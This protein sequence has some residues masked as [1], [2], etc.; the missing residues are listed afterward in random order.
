MLSTAIVIFRETLEIALMLGIVLT[1]TRGLPRRTPWIAGGFLAGAVGA[2][3]VASFAEAISAFAAGVGQEIF[4]ACILFIA[5]GF[6]GCTALW[7]HTHAREMS[8]RLKKIGQDVTD[9]ALPLSALAVIIGLSMLREG[10]EIVLFVYGM[11]LSGQSI[12]S[13]VAGSA[14]GIVCGAAAGIFLYYGLL[15]I[16]LKYMFKVT[17]WMLILLVSGLAAQGAGYLSAA[18]YFP[19]MSGTLWNST[20]LVEDGGIAGKVLHSLIGYS[21]RPTHIEGIFY[22]SM[23]AGML[24]LMDITTGEK[25]KHAVTPR[26]LSNTAT[27][28]AIT[29]T[30]FSMLL[31]GGSKAWALDKIYSPIVEQ[32]EWELEY[33]GSRSF[34]G[35]RAKNNVQ[36]HEIEIGYGFHHWKPELTGEFEK[37]PDESL[38]MS[39]LAFENVFQFF[40]QGEKWLDAGLLATYVQSLEHGKAPNALEVKLLMEKQDGKFLHRTNIGMEQE[41]G[42]KATGGPDLTFQWSSRY[43]YSPRFEPGFEIQ[44]DLGRSDEISTYSTQEHY[45]GPAVY[46]SIVP[47]LKYEVAYLAGVSN[48]AANSA[49]RLLLEYE[50]KL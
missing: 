12:A 26:T 31:S 13:I 10:S 9:G 30:L 7:M 39:S 1:A 32:G 50:I 17:A 36:S 29:L 4:N 34:D 21:A 33:S 45:I 19:G 5:A 27:M 15:K 3:F 20:W 41:I 49:V 2:T 40:D 23:F 11:A 38:I 35:E 42:S 37:E 16:S 18:G 8:G 25:K 44:S 43:R 14:L 46:G 47:G 6:I 28:G 48:A 22:V 24:M